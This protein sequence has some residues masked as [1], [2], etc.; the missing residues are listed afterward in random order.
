M[1]NAQRPLVDTGNYDD[2]GDN[3]LNTKFQ[4]PEGEVT[5]INENEIVIKL[6]SGEDTKIARRTAIQSLNDVAVWTEPKVKVGDK[7]VFTKYAG[8][9]VK[10][11]GEEYIIIGQNDIL[12]VID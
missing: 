9:E 2:L 6:P 3:V 12:A 8:T 11:E 10:Y 7:V 5:E 1:A 4:Y